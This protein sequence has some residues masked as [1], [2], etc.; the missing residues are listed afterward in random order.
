MLGRVVTG[1]TIAAAVA[2]VASAEDV[3]WPA[4]DF[5]RY[6]ALVIGNNDYQHLPKLTTAVADAEA[7]AALLEAKYGFQVSKLINATRRD[8]TGA[9][10]SLRQTLTEKDNLLVYYAGHGVLDEEADRGYWLPVEARRDDDSDWFANTRLSGYLKAMSAQHVMVVAD[11][12]YSGNLTRTVTSTVRSG[13]E[14]TAWMERMNEKRSRTALT[15]GGLEPVLDRGGGGHSVFARAFLAALEENPGVLFGE[16]VFDRVKGVVVAN[17]AQ[18]PEYSDIRYTGHDKGDFLFVPVNRRV[19]APIRPPAAA[20]PTAAADREVVFWQSIQN[21]DDPAMFEA[22]LQQF[23]NGVFA[24]IAR[25]RVRRGREAEA[26][27]EPSQAAE[28]TPVEIAFMLDR[29]ANVRAKPSSRARRVTTLAKGTRVLA[30]GKASVGAWTW[31]RVRHGDRDLG[32][33]RADLLRRAPT[34]ETT[35]AAKPITEAEVEITFWNSIKD[36]RNPREYE[37][38]LHRFPEGTFADLARD[39]AA[40]YRQ[41]AAVAEGSDDEPPP[42]RS[43]P[44]PFDGDW[45]GEVYSCIIRTPYE[46]KATVRAGWLNGTFIDAFG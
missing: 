44:Y 11:S 36:S 38:Y 23:P 29:D 18:T 26:G 10:N 14:W 12:C 31:Y 34:G 41:T 8:I 27:P 33:V 45:E 37:A 20:P 21:S 32:F 13:A 39:R 19:A 9:F 24:P 4:V 35:S 1:L 5:G 40:R 6:H 17:A 42:R 3:M 30:V 46:A 7:V 22:Y 2:A 15:S 43:G 16:E 28:V 25:L